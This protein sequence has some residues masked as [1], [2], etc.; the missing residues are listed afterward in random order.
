MRD[1]YMA[2]NMDF[3]SGMPIPVSEKYFLTK[4]HTYLSCD[5]IQKLSISVAW[6]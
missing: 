6:N 4:N 5:N 1:K 3:A 2:G